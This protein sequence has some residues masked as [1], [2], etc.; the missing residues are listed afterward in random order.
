MHAGDVMTPT[1][2]V[3]W[4]AGIL[5]GAIFALLLILAVDAS[6][7]SRRE[8]SSRKLPPEHDHRHREK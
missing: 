3:M 5:E 1:T 7:R 6:I 4:A 8:R 2:L